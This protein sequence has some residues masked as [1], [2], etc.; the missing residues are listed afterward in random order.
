MIA[1]IFNVVTLIFCVLAVSDSKKIWSK[2]ATVTRF[3]QMND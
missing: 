2:F 1:F 3:M